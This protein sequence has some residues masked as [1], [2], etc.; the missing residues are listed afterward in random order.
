[1][2]KKI[3]IIVILAIFL[4]ATFSSTITAAKNT[5]EENQIFGLIES[6]ISIQADDPQ[7][8]KP[9]GPSETKEIELT[10]K[11]RLDLGDLA[12]RFFFNRRIGR[13][14]L[15]GLGY[16]L[17]AKGEP[18][19]T[20]NLSIA[21]C[22]NWCTAELDTTTIELEIDNKFTEAKAKLQISVNETAPALELTEIT[23]KAEYAGHWTIKG[24][25]N[26]TTISFL[27]AYVSNITYE[28]LTEHTIPPLKNTT[29]PINIT[30]NG[31]GETIVNIE[32]EDPP[33]NWN[34][35]LDPEDITI[36]V[37][38]T[39]QI[40]LTVKPVKGFE[41][42]TITL[43]LTPKSTSEEDV[44]ENELIGDSITFGIIL[45]NDGSLKEEEEGIGVETILLI[46]ILVIVIVVVL[47]LI[48]LKKKVL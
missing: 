27:P 17:K 13:F 22:P 33:E 19:A 26:T 48:L 45:Y 28:A 11:Y 21:D 36:S 2:N 24:T 16:I 23:V 47:I 46:I 1:M 39:E 12:A 34:I 9:I 44:D 41:E 38:K 25:S 7:I 40:N 8:D 4:T 6:E 43:K 18:K 20:I 14:F 42:E 30:N 15:F 29:I 31:N 37:G 32:V 5:S 10:V 3:I 35:S